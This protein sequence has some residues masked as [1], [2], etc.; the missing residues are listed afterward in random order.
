MVELLFW[1]AV[2]SI[3]VIVPTAIAARVL[4]EFSRHE[5]Q[6]YCRR[7]NRQ[8]LFDEI[9]DSHDQFAL[10][11]E[12]LQW[13]GNVCLL[14]TGGLWFVARN[15]TNNATFALPQNYE[16]ALWLGGATFVL[17][18]V[19]SWIPWAMA[20]NASAPF[21]FHT[22]GIWRFVSQLAWPFRIG[23]AGLTW[24]AQRMAGTTDN[25]DEEEEALEEEIR[26]IV[27]AG[28]R[29]GLLESPAREMIEG[30]IELD[31]IDVAEIMTP[32]SRMNVLD[33]K[34]PPQELIHKAI[35]FGHTRIPIFENE[36]DN[37]IGLLFVK[38]LLPILV[39]NQPREKVDVRS[40]L[41][42]AQF[43]PMTIRS[44]DLLQ[45]FRASRSHLSIVVDEYH[46]VMGVVTIEDVLEEIVGEINDE[47]DKIEEQ[48]FTPIDA[49]RTLVN[50]TVHVDDANDHLKIELPVSDEFDTL[51][52][53][54]LSLLARI[55]KSGEVISI[56]NCRIEIKQASRR[57][58]E[59]VAI[60]VL[61]EP[62]LDSKS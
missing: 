4:H 41:R 12:T 58:I 61:E 18:I 10:G 44:D 28:E 27:T 33:I 25:N 53:L 9:L 11:A 51:A 56:E 35:E 48:L 16:V 52:G 17:V 54:I 32:R 59:T 50:A 14:S 13:F 5:L 47:T 24:V 37:M 26:T 19:N 23:Y 30:V 6:A 57:K 60:E 45:M 40:Y 49:N 38:D 36:M 7:R 62:A 43:V 46:S 31:D 3:L 8:D 42:P 15:T 22:W 2:S 39:D 29:D 34:L 21:L 20:K 55:P 1:V